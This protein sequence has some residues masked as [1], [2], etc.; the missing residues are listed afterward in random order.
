[1]I[2][3]ALLPM[4]GCGGGG[5]GGG[6]MSFPLYSWVAVVDVNGDGLPDIVTCYSILSG[7]P[8]HP[9]YVAVYLRDPAHPGAF[10]APAVYAVGNDPVQLAVGDLDGDGR[11]DIVTANAIL[12][13]NGAGASTVSVLLQSHTAPGTFAP[14]ASYATVQNPV[15]VSIGDLNGDG[16]PDLAVAGGGGVALLFQDPAAP[17]TFLPQRS[18]GF[19]G[20]ASSVAVADVDADGRADLVVTNASVVMLARQD[21]AAAGTFLAPASF[22]AG[23]QPIFVAVGDLN[24]DGRRDI[25]VAN[26]GSPSDAFSASVS[27]LLQDPAAGG[28]FV[29]GPSFQVGARTQQLAIAD[30]DG[31]GHPDL[32]VASA[33]TLGGGCPPNCG[34]VGTGVAV[35]LQGP[36]GAAQF[37]AASNYPASGTD[38]VSAV[39]VGDVD[40]DGRPDL[41]IAQSDGVYIRLQD[42]AHPGQFLQ[43]T[44]ISR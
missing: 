41:V 20:A 35:L 22:P 1:M 19:G 32:V 36:G 24:G 38:F 12:S 25:A 7:P 30:L 26:L 33:G 3:F 44:R 21:P 29:G 18:A 4:G 27:L 31:D 39:A 16:R 42:P 6:E 8:P 43:A 28:N 13:T 9:G 17:G 15:S 10:L 34:S 23:Q 40:G 11:P 37:Q 5:G 2:V 14:A